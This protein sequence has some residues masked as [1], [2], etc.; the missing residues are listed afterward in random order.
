[1][2]KRKLRSFIVRWVGVEAFFE[3]QKNSEILVGLFFTSRCKLI[4]L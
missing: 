1:M 2:T 3:A 4:N